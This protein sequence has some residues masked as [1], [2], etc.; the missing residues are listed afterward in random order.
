MELRIEFVPVE[1]LKVQP[2]SPK[3]HDLAVLGDS[4]DRFGFSEAIVLDERTGYVIAGQ[5]RVEALLLKRSQA[6]A[7]PEGITEDWQAPIVRGW[8]SKD[9]GEA[10]AFLIAANATTEKGGWNDEQLYQLLS[11]FDFLTGTG[12]DSDALDDLRARIEEAGEKLEQMIEKANQV[13]RQVILEYPVEDF[14]YVTAVAAR[15]RPFYEVETNAELFAA[16]LEERA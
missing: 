8:S 13:L 12:F 2:D 14:E 10:V 16:M 9:D 6:E 3:R 4:Y 15:A 5:G 1:M 11:G 7:P